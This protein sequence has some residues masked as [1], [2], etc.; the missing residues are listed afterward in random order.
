MQN[1]PVK[2]TVWLSGNWINCTDWPTYNPLRQ[3][4]VRRPTI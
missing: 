3:V 4:T 2:R 1:Y